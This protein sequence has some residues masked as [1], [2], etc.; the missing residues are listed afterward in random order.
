[1]IRFKD[2]Y[3]NN[4]DWWNSFTSCFVGTLLG[5]GITFGISEYQDQ[6]SKADLDHKLRLI[7]VENMRKSSLSIKNYCDIYKAEDSIY[8]TVLKYYPDSLDYIDK[9]LA[10]DFVNTI[11]RT[12]FL[13]SNNYANNFINNNIEVLTSVGDISIV[14]TI[15][16]FF[17]LSD[18]LKKRIPDCMLKRNVVVS[19]PDGN[20]HAEI[21]CLVLLDDK[22]FA[23]E[24]KHW[25]GAV[26]ER[27]DG[28]HKYKY[29]ND[30]DGVWESVNKSPF[31]QVK[32]AVSILKKQT[33]NRDWIQ[34][35]V[36]I[37]GASSVQI[38]DD[39]VWFD[40]A[41]KLADYIISYKDSFCAN[42]RL[43]GNIRCF[44]S[45]VSYDFIYT[46]YGAISIN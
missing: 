44:Y 34:T 35:V 8:C 22:L 38:S 27:D 42:R 24:I 33:H 21:D 17:E 36:Y 18:F 25:K 1:M 2:L 29:K 11:Y 4:R 30:A 20:A 19:L 32:R 7:S 43:N 15:N 37:E 40:D 23:I 39:G 41:G 5:I 10:G 26:V 13:S 31:Q 46:S 45:A 3:N 12:N 28:F 9:K 14:N 6:K 16:G